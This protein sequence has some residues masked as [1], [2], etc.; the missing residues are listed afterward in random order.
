MMTRL[1]AFHGDPKVKRFYLMRVRQHRANDEL[2]KGVY[3][4][5]GKG[6]AI[7]CAIHSDDHAAYETELGI[8]RLLARLEDGIF[9]GLPMAQAQRWPEAFLR[10]IPVGADLSMVWP[11]FAVWLLGD[12]KDGVLRSAK[13][14]TTRH[15]IQAVIRL[16][17]GLSTWPP[18][19][20]E[21]ALFA[22]AA[23]AA[24]AAWAAE[25]ADAAKAAD[26]ANAAW[27]ADA[28][29]AAGAR[30][31]QSNTLLSLLR[32]AP[33]VEEPMVSHVGDGGMLERSG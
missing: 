11:Q 8:P 12:P 33:V 21:A 16:Y 22:E 6:C 9:E 20:E 15:A 17:Q 32:A 19:R 3:W 18:S 2:I 7:G 4:Q 27:A 26:A 5:E 23:E 13:N 30:V 31:Q 25:A 24:N 14:P 1:R 29:W 10:A 28:A